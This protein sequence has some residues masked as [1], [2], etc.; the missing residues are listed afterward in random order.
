MREA[1]DGADEHGMVRGA[2]EVFDCGG[3]VR[4]LD[5]RGGDVVFCGEGEAG[6]HGCVGEGGV[7]EGVVDHFGEGVDGDVGEGDDRGSWGG[8]G[9]LEAGEVGKSRCV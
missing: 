4:W 9:G 1:D 8:H 3:D 7:E 5:A 2:G 6:G